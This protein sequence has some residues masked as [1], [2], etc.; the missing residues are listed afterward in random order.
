MSKTKKQ[1]EALQ[2]PITEEQ[3]QYAKELAESEPINLGNVY[4]ALSDFQLEVPILVKNTQG[5]GY[6][7]VDL[8]EIVSTIT[9]I[10]SRHKLVVVQYLKGHGIV[11][12]LVHTPSMTKID[13]YVEIPQNVN[14]K[15]QNEYQ[16]YG[17]A[18][19]Y[20]RRYQWVTICGLVA[21][22]DTDATGKQTNTN[23]PKL[24]SSRFSDAVK[25]VKEGTFTLEQ[26]TEHYTLSQAQKLELTNI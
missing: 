21:D 17:S 23:K 22:V 11:T 3:A 1:V 13:S 2:E 16:A 24:D 6:K 18:I 15:G 19:T 20:F 5:Y 8:T 4:E 12:E 25:A 9:P 26:I 14:L 7:Y 10:L